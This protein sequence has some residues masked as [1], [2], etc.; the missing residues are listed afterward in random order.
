M[1]AKSWQNKFKAA[2]KKCKRTSKKSA[3]KKGVNFQN[4]MKRELKGK[5]KGKKR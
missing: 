1:A 5:G 4:C 2:A 3:S